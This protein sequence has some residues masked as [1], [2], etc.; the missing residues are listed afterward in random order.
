MTIFVTPTL[1][2]IFNTDRKKKDIESIASY[3]KTAQEII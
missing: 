1:Y 2:S 3:Q